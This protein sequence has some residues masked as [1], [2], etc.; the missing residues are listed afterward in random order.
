MQVVIFSY[1]LIHG[2]YDNTSNRI[3]RMFLIQLMSADDTPLVK[4]H[5]S[6]CQRMVLR[7]KCVSAEADIKKRHK[8][9]TEEKSEKG[10]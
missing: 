1:L 4:L 3:R 6:D 2:S 7:G 9:C 5:H 10:S 8:E